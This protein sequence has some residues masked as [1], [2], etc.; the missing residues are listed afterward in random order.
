MINDT[1]FAKL[2]SKNLKPLNRQI[3]LK[4]AGGDS[5]EIS[6]QF[7]I[8]FSFDGKIK[9]IP[10]LVVPR[11]AVD[12]LCGM[13]FWNKFQISPIIQYTAFAEELISPAPP[14]DTIL[15]H[16]EQEMIENIKRTF[17]TARPGQLSTTPLIPLSGGIRSDA[18]T[19]NN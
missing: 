19:G 7:M 18:R 16:S 14:K 10:T 8:P 12:C 2:K 11:L 9:I 3:I 17:K 13:D 5:L 6:G 4:T 15:N 1:L